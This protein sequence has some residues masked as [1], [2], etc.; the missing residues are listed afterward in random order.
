MS[1]TFLPRLV[2]SVASGAAVESSGAQKKKNL[3]QG[4]S[5]EDRLFFQTKG[6]EL[7]DLTSSPVVVVVVVVT[8]GSIRPSVRPRADPGGQSPWTS[9]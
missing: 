8:Y 3:S 5:H 1:G 9:G 2:L 7:V 4:A 6:A